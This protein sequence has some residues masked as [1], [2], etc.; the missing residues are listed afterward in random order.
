MSIASRSG[1]VRVVWGLVC[2]GVGVVVVLAGCLRCGATVV[3]R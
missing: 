1:S 3:V 2:V